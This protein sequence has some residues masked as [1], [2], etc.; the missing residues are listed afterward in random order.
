MPSLPARF[1]QVLVDVLIESAAMRYLLNEGI[2]SQAGGDPF[3]SERAYRL[4][5]PA[6][7]ILP[8]AAVAASTSLRYESFLRPSNPERIGTVAA[9]CVPAFYAASTNRGSGLAADR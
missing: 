5:R 4:A 6:A 1:R 3:A 2:T 7:S 8:E 9:H